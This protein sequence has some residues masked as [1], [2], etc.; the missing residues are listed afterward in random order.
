MTLRPAEPQAGTI[1]QA[2]ASERAAGDFPDISF[3]E[4]AL[5][6]VSDPAVPLADGR[7]AWVFLRTAPLTPLND[8]IGRPVETV[9]GCGI[10]VLDAATGDLIFSA[11]AGTT[12]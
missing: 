2:A 10:V 12:Q 5:V 11:S 6:I 9:D 4:T 8:A 3:S 7:L 1:S